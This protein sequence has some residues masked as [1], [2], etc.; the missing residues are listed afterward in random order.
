MD[1]MAV[2][3]K[4]MHVRGAG[5]INDAGCSRMRPSPRRATRP[6]SARSLKAAAAQLKATRPTAVSLEWGVWTGNLPP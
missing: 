6:A 1:D 5:L 4:D 3:I 2:A